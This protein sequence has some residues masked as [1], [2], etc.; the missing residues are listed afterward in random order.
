MIVDR[1]GLHIDRHVGWRRNAAELRNAPRLRCVA[2]LQCLDDVIAIGPLQVV[3]DVLVVRIAAAD[4]ARQRVLDQQAVKLGAT[5]V[6][7]AG[8]IALGPDN[9]QCEC[10]PTDEHLVELLVHF[11]QRALCAAARHDD[12]PPQTNVCL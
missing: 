4:A 8:E 5:H 11:V 12:I 9:F 3:V 1:C 7:F 10:L 2:L 6:I